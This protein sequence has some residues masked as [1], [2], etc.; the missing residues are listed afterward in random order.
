MINTEK[1]III[2]DSIYIK[3]NN[4]NY[5]IQALTLEHYT[6]KP[7]YG[8]VYINIYKK[9]KWNTH[10]LKEP[11]ATCIVCLADYTSEWFFDFSNK[12][13]TNK[14]NIEKIIKENQKIHKKHITD[15]VIINNSIHKIDKNISKAIK[16]LNETG[17]KT[18]FCCEGDNSSMGY[19]WLESGL[20]PNELLKVWSE[21]GF[22][23]TKDFVYAEAPF[24]LWD[25]ASQVFK[26]TLNDW[27]NNRLD[28]TCSK[29]SISTERPCSLPVLY[30]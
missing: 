20:F 12:V 23:I 30:E 18:K 2:L 6:K 25:K 13:T 9:N 5:E 10:K 7:D 19:I 15:E 27:L 21:I 22:D 17:V 11:F 24:G 3:K 29:Y 16:K 4:I 1:T 14:K 26:N 8:I 28:F